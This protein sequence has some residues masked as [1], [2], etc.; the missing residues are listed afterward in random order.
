MG[1]LLIWNLPLKLKIPQYK[2]AIDN[3]TESIRLIPFADAYFHRGLANRA[4]GQCR[5]TLGQ[6]KDDQ[7]N[8]LSL[9]EAAVRDLD[10]AIIDQE[11]AI[12]LKKIMWDIDHVE[13]IKKDYAD[14]YHRRGYMKLMVAEE[15]HIRENKKEAQR[16]YEAAVED[17]KEAIRINPNLKTDVQQMQKRAEEALEQLKR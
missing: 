1:Y 12:E 15:L 5:F 4:L 6:S 17:C 16:L 13:A 11:E 10:K 8:R 2:R 7:E 9:Y 3:F 14:T